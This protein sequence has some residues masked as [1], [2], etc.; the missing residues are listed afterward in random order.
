[1][2]FLY[3]R[4]PILIYLGAC[5]TLHK[6]VFPNCYDMLE[7]LR[8]YTSVDSVLGRRLFA[9]SPC[10]YNPVPSLAQGLISLPY[11][12]LAFTTGVVYPT[13]FPDGRRAFIASY[14][15][16]VNFNASGPCSK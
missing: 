7:I 6:I 14:A 11:L 9:I 15:S 5:R 2:E 8:L 13:R 10:V 12:L 3:F 4:W 16:I 1:M